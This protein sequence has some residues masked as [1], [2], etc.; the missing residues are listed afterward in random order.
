MSVATPRVTPPDSGP[1]MFVSRR[2]I[3]RRT[4]LRVSG[5]ID[6]ASVPTLAD[7]IDSALGDGALEL[8]IDLSPTSFMDSSGLRLLLELWRRLSQVN[9]RLAIIC[10]RGPVRR[11]FDVAGFSDRLPLFDEP[12]AAH[13]PS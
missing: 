7:A 13:L 8:W 12:A 5:E 11:V 9:R 4:V 1:A 3:G 2:V 10:P 6:F